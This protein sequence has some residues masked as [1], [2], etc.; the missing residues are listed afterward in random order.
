MAVGLG[1]TGCS[2]LTPDAAVEAAE[3]QWD[4]LTPAVQDALG[5]HDQ[6]EF[7]T[8]NVAEVWVVRAELDLD[9][10][11]GDTTDPA[12][13]RTASC[14]A[15]ARA[16]ADTDLR[17]YGWLPV[18]PELVAAG[19]DTCVRGL[20][21]GWWTEGARPT[22]PTGEY[23]RHGSLELGRAT[24]GGQADLVGVT[25]DLVDLTLEASSDASPWSSP[26]VELDAQLFDQ[27]LGALATPL[28]T[29]LVI[30]DNIGRQL[31]VAVPAGSTV[32]ATAS[33]PTAGP[34]SGRV[35]IETTTA[36][37]RVAPG[38]LGPGQSG[39]AAVDCPGTATAPLAP[40]DR[41]QTLTGPADV[42]VV[43]AAGV[44]G[45]TSYDVQLR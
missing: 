42:V 38:A 11:A 31:V 5:L 3:Q 34:T 35:A 17:A 6:D 9:V 29:D 45:T 36:T 23:G 2:I 37:I 28:P 32:T 25:L 10:P 18:G 40:A 4:A 12:A 41:V 19:P 24:D 15:V 20:G 26:V 43:R 7:P 33:C 16:L 1:A 39:A 13:V 27:R 21:G 14:L 8:G 30:S 44:A 22:G